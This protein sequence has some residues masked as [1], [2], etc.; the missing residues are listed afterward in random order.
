MSC[1]IILGMHR[2]GTSAVAAALYKMGVFMG[3]RL[4]GPGPWNPYGHFEDIE[5]VAVNDAM[6]VTAGGS[7]YTPPPEMMVRTV[8]WMFVPTLAR[9]VKKREERGLSWGFKDPRTALTVGV[10]HGL[11][12]EP[13]Y[14]VCT[15]NPPDVVASLMRR[16]SEV[17]QK[18]RNDGLA[19]SYP[20]QREVAHRTAE[21]WYRVL[22]EYLSRIKSFLDAS[23]APSVEISYDEL[24]GDRTAEEMTRLATFVG[25]ENRIADGLEAIIKEGRDGNDSK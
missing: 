13:H 4:M 10:Y 24:M 1:Y 16:E 23:R 25:T 3:E 15:R 14:I 9:L 20:W 18:I 19:E 6:L 7:W 5:F 21:D 17:W 2:S 12:P 8:R 22:G 11:L